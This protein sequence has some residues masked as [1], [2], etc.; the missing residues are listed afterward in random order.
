MSEL[1]M[2]CY[3]D[4]PDGSTGYGRQ[5]K[6][7]LT[8]LHQQGFKIAVIGINHIDNSPNEPFYFF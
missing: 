8:R 2:L 4:S 3:S 6:N 7:I 5:A 1:K